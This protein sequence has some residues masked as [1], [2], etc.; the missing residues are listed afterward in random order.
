MK[1]GP[2]AP[3]TLSPHRSRVLKHL[4]THLE[5]IMVANRALSFQNALRGQ[6]VA[7]NLLRAE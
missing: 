7:G 4:N 3:V 2:A 6:R 1:R 5:Q